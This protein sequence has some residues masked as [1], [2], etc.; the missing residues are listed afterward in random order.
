MVLIAASIFSKSGKGSICFANFSVILTLFLSLFVHFNIISISY[1]GTAI[2]CLGPRMSGSTLVWIRALFHQIMPRVS[3]WPNLSFT[4]SHFMDFQRS[5]LA[6]SSNWRELALRVYSM[7]SPSS[8]APARTAVSWA[9]KRE[10]T[11]LVGW[12]LREVE[13]KAIVSDD[14]RVIS[15]INLS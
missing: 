7:P 5:F 8:S 15:T 1:F 9:V 12:H 10:Y 14:S 13:S 6:S 2:S 4:M 11:C 3:S